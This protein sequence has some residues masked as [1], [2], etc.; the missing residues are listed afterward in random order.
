VDD[1]ALARRLAEAESDGLHGRRRGRTQR[2]T[3]KRGECVPC[4]IREI[5]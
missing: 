5:R 2:E 1:G 4:P 3:L